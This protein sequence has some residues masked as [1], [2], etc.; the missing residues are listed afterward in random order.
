MNKRL[1]F[2][3]TIKV[4]FLLL[5]TA[6]NC[7]FFLLYLVSKLYENRMISE[8]QNPTTHL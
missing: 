2:K 1:S 7:Q 6:K 3:K 5:F 8:I 4:M